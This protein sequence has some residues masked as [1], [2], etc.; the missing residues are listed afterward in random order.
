MLLNIQQRPTA[1]KSRESS[2][3]RAMPASETAQP[4]GAVPKGISLSSSEDPLIGDQL[5]RKQS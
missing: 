2:R 3:L 5:N 1:R 4:R